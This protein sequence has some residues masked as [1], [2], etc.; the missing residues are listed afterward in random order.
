M[1]TYLGHTNLDPCGVISNCLEDGCPHSQPAIAK[2]H[3]SKVKLPYS[4]RAIIFETYNF[5]MFFT[6]TQLGTLL[7]CRARA[8]KCSVLSCLTPQGS[9]DDFEGLK[10]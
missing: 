9:V 7:D 2:E 4:V 8:H 5:F 1:Y 10:K 3:E 6:L